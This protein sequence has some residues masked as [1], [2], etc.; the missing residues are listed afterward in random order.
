MRKIFLAVCLLTAALPAFSADEETPKSRTLDELVET[1]L[2][3]GI[4]RPV[5]SDVAESLGLSGEVPTKAVRYKASESPDKWDHAFHVIYAPDAEGEPKSDQLIWVA[6]KKKTVA[7][8]KHV[9][10]MNFLVG[11]D[12]KLLA[13]SSV[14][15]LANK[16]PAI[17]MD[18]A[19]SKTKKAF[20]KEKKF[21]LTD[22]LS[23]EFSTK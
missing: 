10:L 7:G 21:Y 8:E 14:N 1:V 4:D 13:A 5:N 22:S 9:E 20:A 16:T 11:V 3:N 17:K 19:S 12:G 2:K 23:L 18:I 15:G 6:G